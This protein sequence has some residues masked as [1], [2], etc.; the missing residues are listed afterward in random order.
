VLNKYA[1]P[2]E[3]A[4]AGK[5]LYKIADIGTMFLRAYISGDQLSKIKIG[6]QVK[7]YIDKD[8]N[9]LQSMTGI[10]NWISSQ[11]EFTPKI[12]QTKDERV[13][14]VYAIKVKVKNDGQLKIGM[15]GEVKFN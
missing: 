4:V 7:I 8:K 13:N 5:P 14:M 15:P 11:S 3:I 2:Y 1:E 9:E 6:Q 10:I 12:I